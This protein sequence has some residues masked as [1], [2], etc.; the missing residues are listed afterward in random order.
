MIAGSFGRYV[1]ISARDHETAWCEGG[2]AKP[3]PGAA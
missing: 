2:T 3:A 1:A